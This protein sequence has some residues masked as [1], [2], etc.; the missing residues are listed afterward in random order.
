M[1]SNQYRLHIVESDVCVIADM[2]VVWKEVCI[3]CCQ[4]HLHLYLG[5]DESNWNSNASRIEVRTP[6]NVK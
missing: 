1:L 6:K 4:Y 2:G 3:T 5:A